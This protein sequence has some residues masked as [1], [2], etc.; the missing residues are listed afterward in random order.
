[1]AFSL[2]ESLQ[3]SSGY[4][5]LLK[6]DPNTFEVKHPEE[7]ASSDKFAQAAI[8]VVLIGV[9]KYSRTDEG[10]VSLVQETSSG[11]PLQL[12]FGENKTDV[13]NKVCEY[14]GE[15]A[16]V[17]ESKM[18][19]IATDAIRIIREHLDQTPE[20]DQVKDLMTAQ[21]QDILSYLPGSIQIGKLLNDETLDDRT[22]KMEGPVSGIMHK[23]GQV[24]SSSGND[25][26]EEQNF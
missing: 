4:P 11:S 13:I 10:N 20:N 23:I 6:I 9:Y 3:K 7:V 16:S 26:K 2:I 19:T 15:T 1:M 12:L 21:R 22:N 24:F 25:K 8:P 14:S 5:K 18:A 17:V